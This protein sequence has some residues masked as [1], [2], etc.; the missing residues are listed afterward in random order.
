MAS[1]DPT[2]EQ[3][4][5]LVLRVLAGLVALTLAGGVAS[6]AGRMADEPGSGSGAATDAP[7]VGAGV[8]SPR[9]GIGPLAGTAV[10]AY[11]RARSAALADVPGSER[12]AAVVSFAAYQSVDA[13]REAVAGLRAEALLVALPGGRPVQVEVDADLEDVVADQ[14]REAAAEKAA[15]EDLLPTVSDEDFQEQYEADIERLSALLDAP[16]GAAGARP[17]VHAVLVTGT[18]DA[19]RRTARVPGV[20]LVDPGADAEVPGVGAAAGLRP[21]E[22]VRAGEPPSRPVP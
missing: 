20:R 22:T 19:L 13:A 8:L 15:L 11:E 14:R 3:L 9:G 7:V 21:E 16:K 2:D 6:A 17:L 12:R 1:P 10:P 18:G 4:T 5:R